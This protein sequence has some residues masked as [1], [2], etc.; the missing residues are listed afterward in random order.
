MKITGKQS[1]L[2]KLLRLVYMGQQEMRL[3]ITGKGFVEVTTFDD[4]IVDG[5]SNLYA[6]AC[7]SHQCKGSDLYIRLI[8]EI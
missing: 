2:T 8:N 7:S 4:V 6:V 3:Q 1:K 5:Q